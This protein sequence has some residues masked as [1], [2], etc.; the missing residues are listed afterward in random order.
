MGSELGS[1]AVERGG[2]WISLDLGN[3]ARARI[4]EEEGRREDSPVGSGGERKGDGGWGEGAGSQVTARV[5]QI[6]Q[7]A[8]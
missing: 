2:F 8:L 4:G 6:S 5:G 1:E 3:G 7:G